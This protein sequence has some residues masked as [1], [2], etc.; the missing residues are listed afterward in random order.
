MKFNEARVRAFVLQLA[1]VPAPPVIDVSMR[2]QVYLEAGDK[3]A[4]EICA[5]LGIGYSSW[6]EARSLLRSA[7]IIASV[8]NNGPPKPV[9]Y[10]LLR[11]RDG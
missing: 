9:R 8:S 7:R 4:E 10:T 6:V 3:T 1:R 2:V 11:R 5:G